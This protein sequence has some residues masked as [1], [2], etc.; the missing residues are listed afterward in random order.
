MSNVYGMV[1]NR[2]L[3]LLEKGTVPWRKPWKGVS[4]M[5]CN[6]VSKREY[7]GIN[8]FLLS[9]MEYNSP[10]WMTYRQAT[11]KGGHVR[12]GEKA[13]PVIFW[14]WIDRKD[15]NDPEAD[16]S[17]KIPLL[18]YY[19]VFNV[20]QCEG[21]KVPDPEEEIHIFS[22]V[23]RAEEIVTYMPN[24]PVISYGGK[25]ASYSPLGDSI[26]M[27]TPEQFIS[28]EEFYSTL[29]HELT[30]STGHVSRVG[31]K[32]VQEPSYFGSHEYSKEELVAEMG[33]AFLCASSGI[34]QKTLENSAAYISGWLSELKNDK[35]MLV[36]A[37]A[38]AQK[39]ADYILY[40][41]GGEES[42]ASE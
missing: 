22:P 21:I 4:G 37:A 24:R 12:Q 10:Y 32:S 27:P 9:A 42:E 11:E 17:G 34:E 38:Q 3:E 19:S 41:K 1:N 29:F 36:T 30:H 13:T 40:R 7:H 26:K 35:K 2:I 39:A 15:S 28:S 14:K 25:S 8:L 6:L 20:E 33:A 5:P 23:E 31:R 16:A 18:R